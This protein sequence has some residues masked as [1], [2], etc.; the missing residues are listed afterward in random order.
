MKRPTCGYC[1]AWDRHH[2]RC[3]LGIPVFPVKVVHRCGVPCPIYT[4]VA[5]TCPFPKSGKAL[6]KAREA[7]P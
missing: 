4:P 7:L 5:C 1:W 2:E 3:T 6:A